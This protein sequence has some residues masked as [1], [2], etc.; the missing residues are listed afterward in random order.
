MRISTSR[1]MRHKMKLETTN[2]CSFCNDPDVLETL[3]H[4]FLH[5]PHS[6]AFFHKLKSFIIENFDTSYVDNDK[7]H[8]IACNHE[9]H[10]VNYMNVVGK[11]FISRSYQMKTPISWVV[12]V[13][14][15]RKI[16]L[17]EKTNIRESILRS[18]T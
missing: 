13:R 12:F 6:Q 16:Q 1:Y 4:I 5:C 17:G 11:W 7:L 8:L 14:M 3:E 15:L 18:L 2:I 9:N 10:L